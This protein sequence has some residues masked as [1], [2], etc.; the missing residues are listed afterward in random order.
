MTAKLE[1]R[2]VSKWFE[3]RSGDV[4]EALRGVTFDVHAGEFVSVV[5][6]SG[7]GKTTLLRLVDGLLAPSRGVQAS[8]L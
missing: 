2:G 8:S 5:G 1:L 4:V 7:C 3:T 6:A